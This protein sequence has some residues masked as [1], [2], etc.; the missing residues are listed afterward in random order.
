MGKRGKETM[1]NE[2]EMLEAADEDEENR[3]RRRRIARR[4]FDEKYFDLFV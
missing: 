4:P 3:Q 1:D 2:L